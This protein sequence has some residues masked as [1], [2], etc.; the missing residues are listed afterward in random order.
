MK[1]TKKNRNTVIVIS[2]LLMAVVLIGLSE[3]ALQND[4]SEREDLALEKRLSEMIETLDGVS[5]AYIM[6]TLDSVSRNSE[7]V[8]VRGVSVVCRGKKS[9]SLKITITMLVSTAVGISSDKI[10]VSFT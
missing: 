1:L 8:T 9:E 3:V 7:T 5:K 4:E 6:V 10:F 2:L